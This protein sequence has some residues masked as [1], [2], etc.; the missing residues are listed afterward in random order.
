L[1]A[2]GGAAIAVLVIG[3]S[4]IG[5]SGPP[6]PISTTYQGGCTDHYSLPVI[7]SVIATGG[8]A[9]AIAGVASDDPDS[10]V[11]AGALFGGAAGLAALPFVISALVGYRSVADCRAKKRAVGL[12]ETRVTRRIDAFVELS[13]PLLLGTYSFR[14]HGAPSGSQGGLV[15]AGIGGNASMQ[16]GR[17]ELGAGARYT[18]GPGD[19]TNAHFI[20]VP[21]WI[22]TRFRIGDNGAIRTA[23][24]AGPAIAIV[25]RIGSGASIGPSGEVSLGYLHRLRAGELHIEVGARFDTMK[26]GGLN[27]DHGQIPFLRVGLGW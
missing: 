14:A 19:P 16:H 2:V 25:P 20:S 10:D 1:C 13:T 17:L 9:A 12:G 18:L 8:I 21:L 7:D 15:E 6:D 26:S 27:I 22:A 4:F 24:G 5:V 11:H 3:C 23:A